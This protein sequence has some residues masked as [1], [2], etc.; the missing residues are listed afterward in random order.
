MMTDLYSKDSTD[1]A[2]YYEKNKNTALNRLQEITE[3]FS[4]NKS[5]D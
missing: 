1:F 4:E 3:F 5:G 2:S